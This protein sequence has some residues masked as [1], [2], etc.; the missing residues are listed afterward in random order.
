MSKCLNWYSQ[1]TEQA[2]II[3]WP[4]PTKFDPSVTKQLKLFGYVI[5]VLELTK[6]IENKNVKNKI[7]KSVI[8]CSLETQT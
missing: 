7:F 3:S 6:I 4:H 2:K 1:T 5:Q 8:F